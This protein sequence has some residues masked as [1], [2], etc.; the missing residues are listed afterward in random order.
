[1]R[2]PRIKAVCP[3]CMRAITMADDRTLLRHNRRASYRKGQMPD[4]CP[5]SGQHPVDQ[6]RLDV[7]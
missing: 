6:S 5:G 2:G 7:A 1:V 4:R 3:V